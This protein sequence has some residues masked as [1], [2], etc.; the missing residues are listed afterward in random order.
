MYYI[1]LSRGAMGFAL[2][3]F[4]SVVIVG[5]PCGCYPL[6]SPT[7]T[8]TTELGNCTCSV[9]FLK[10]RRVQTCSSQWWSN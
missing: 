8:D 9:C 6:T 7:L 5:D 4:Y 10:M 2:R 1:I 3:L